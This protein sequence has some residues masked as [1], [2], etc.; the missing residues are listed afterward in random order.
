MESPGCEKSESDKKSHKTI[1]KL[2]II[3]ICMLP[4]WFVIWLILLL[5]SDQH[6]INSGYKVE[7]GNTFYDII[8]Y[9]ID[10]SFPL[11]FIIIAILFCITTFKIIKHLKSHKNNL[12]YIK[13]SLTLNLSALVVS[14]LLLVNC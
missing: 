11:L 10:I 4:L 5:I 6:Y 7:K 9:S 8:D 13:I 1:L 12:G 14:I 2:G 3:N